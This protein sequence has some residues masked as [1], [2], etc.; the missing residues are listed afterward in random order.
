MIAIDRVREHPANQWQPGFLK[1]LPEIES[2]LKHAFRKLGPE[3]GEDASEDGIL[4]CL[5][6]YARLFAHG[7]EQSASPSTLVWYA[8]LQVRRGRQALCPMNVGEPLSRYGQ[9]R[10]GIQVMSLHTEAAAPETWVGA[11]VDNYRFSVA[12]QVAARM[13]IRS[14][15]ATLSSRTRQ[16]ATD[17]AFGFSTSELARKYRLSKSRISQLR[18]MLERSWSVFQQDC[19]NAL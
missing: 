10:G 19:E 16:I 13:D 1:M 15:L 2:R 12:D 11:L 18:R 9:L 17:M 14:W 5:V 3:A 4:H 7:R 8:V 6:S